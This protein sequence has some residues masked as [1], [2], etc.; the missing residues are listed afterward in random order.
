M[1]FFLFEVGCPS[2]LA[3][4]DQGSPPG[5]RAHNGLRLRQWREHPPGYG[6]P[7]HMVSLKSPV[8]SVK[9]GVLENIPAWWLSPAPLKHM[10]VRWDNDIPKIWGKNVPKH[11]PDTISRWFFY[12]NPNFE[13]I[14]QLATFDDT[15]AYCL[16]L[17]PWRFWD[18]S[19]HDVGTPTWW[20]HWFTYFPRPL[21]KPTMEVKRTSIRHVLS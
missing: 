12:W 13:W 17:L 21:G 9:H 19:T 20:T 10:K 11:Q 8:P 1:G 16:L 15:K 7:S 3:L 14:S 4:S 6:E 5:V 2:I 18:G